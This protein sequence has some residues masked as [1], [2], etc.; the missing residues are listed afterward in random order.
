MMNDDTTVI[1]TEICIKFWNA[2]IASIPEILDCIIYG[3][4]VYHCV[5]KESKSGNIITVHKDNETNS[6]VISFSVDGIENQTAYWKINYDKTP[7]K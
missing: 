5:C 6:T 1:T 3:P 4:G 2:F 7:P